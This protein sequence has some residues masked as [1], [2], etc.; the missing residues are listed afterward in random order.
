[1]FTTS[2]H[3][4]YYHQLVTLLMVEHLD[5]IDTINGLALEQRSY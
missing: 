2:I 4:N 3:A 1:M 5:R